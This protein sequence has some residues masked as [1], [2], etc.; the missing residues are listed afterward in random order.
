MTI[1]SGIL[2]RKF[3]VIPN[4][5]FAFFLGAGASASSNI[6]TAFEMTEDFKR[7]LYASEKSIKLTTIEQRYYDFKEDIDNWVKIKFK[8]T[9][10]NEYAF[11]FEKTFPSKK[12]RTEYVRKSVGLAKPS[13]GYKIL[14]FLIEKKIVWHFITTNF[15][16]L[17]QKVYPNVIEITE[18]NIKTHEQKININPE[19]PIVIKLH[20]DFRYDWLRNIDTET[21]TL[22]SSV[23]ESLK[24]LFKYLGLIV[25]GYSGRDESVMSFVEKFIEE[26]DRPFPQGFYWCIKEDGNYNSRAKTLIERLKEKGIE[27]NFIKISSFDDLLIEI[28][29]QLDENDNKI[30]EWLSDNRVLQPFRVS[31]RYDNKFIV[32]NYLRIIDYPQTFLTFKYKNIQNWEDLTALTEGKHI[33]ASFFREKNIIALGDEGQIRETFKDYIED[34]IEYYTL[35]END[36]NELNKQRGFIYGI[37]YEIFNWYFLN[38]LGLKRF[39][40]KRVFYK[41][42]IYE[43]KLPRYSRK[44]RYF[45]AFNYSIEFRDKKLLFILTPYYITADFESIDRDTYKIRQNFLISNM[46]NRDVLTDLIYWQKVL[47]RNGREFIKIE[48]PSGTLKFLIQSKFYKC[49]KAL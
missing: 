15:D 1:N 10:D 44:I 9:P 17:V 37:Y 19:Y 20:G 48:L 42:Q 4:K 40:K 28:Y 34:E 35:T 47:I 41:E 29:K 18:E 13:I 46:W 36:L 31:N 45:K 2:A 33:I 11:F 21:Q 38:V 43:K 27:A 25:I 23:L 39:N 7:R 26:E 30:D 3:G 49:G 22:C 24:G 5:K 6:P 32:L 14:R 12:D 16:N 8:S